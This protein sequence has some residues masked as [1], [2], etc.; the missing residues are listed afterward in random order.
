MFFTLDF[1]F[2][3]QLLIFHYHHIICSIFHKYVFTMT[4]LIPS[5]YVF[6]S[7]HI[8]RLKSKNMVFEVMVLDMF[9]GK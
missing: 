9:L 1:F 2:F 7:N 8:Y 6:M 3:C 4:E 5:L